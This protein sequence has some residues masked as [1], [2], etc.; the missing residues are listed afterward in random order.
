ML[1][2]VNQVL[3][4]NRAVQTEFTVSVGES[5]A[6]KQR[7]SDPTKQQLQMQVKFRSFHNLVPPV[8]CSLAH[9]PSLI[10]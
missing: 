2:S 8:L 6:Q 10:S 3:V 9:L 1:L 5:A 4:P 7:S